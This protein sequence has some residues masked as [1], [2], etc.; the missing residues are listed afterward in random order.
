[1]A[2]KSAGVQRE[3]M[4]NVEDL[5]FF[6]R[7][8]NQWEKQIKKKDKELCNQTTQNEQEVAVEIR[9]SPESS[10]P[11]CVSEITKP[12]KQGK[13]ETTKLKISSFDYAAWDKFDAEAECEKIDEEKSLKSSEDSDSDEEL[14]LNRKRQQAILEKDKGNAFLKSGKIDQAI[15][16][17]TKGNQLDPENALLLANRALAFIKNKQ[18]GAA[19]SDCDAALL[20]DPSYVKA[21]LR[22]AAAREALRKYDKAV[23][24]L[25]IVLQHEPHNK[26]S[27]NSLEKLRKIV[28]KNQT[29]LK[30]NDHKQQP[31]A[32]KIPLDPLGEIILPIDK[33]HHLS[34]TKPLRRIKVETVNSDITEVKTSKVPRMESTITTASTSGVV[35]QTPALPKSPTSFFRFQ[36]DFTKLKSYPELQYQYFKSIPCSQYAS[37]FREN[38]EP[39]TVSDVIEL[40]AKFYI[41]NNDELYEPVKRL[42]L[43]KRFSTLKLFFSQTDK[44]YLKQIFDHLRCGE[45]YKDFEIGDLVEEY[46]MTMKTE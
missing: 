24:D 22:R 35:K 41:Q 10:K 31:L 42:A 45:N 33:P 5:Q 39:N 12:V 1:M 46:G 21:Y 38:L 25:E 27:L 4:N 44:N 36:A 40:F 26:E 29:N 2:N 37:L 34:T 23:E 13:D 18:Y 7:D 9:N 43:T 6:L 19:E 15:E 3:M 32:E 16:C 14:E 28:E 11:P 30:K 17:Y 8:L 20:L